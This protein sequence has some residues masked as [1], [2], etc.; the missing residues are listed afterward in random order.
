VP[1]SFSATGNADSSYLFEIGKEAEMSDLISLV[2]FPFGFDH[3]LNTKEN[4]GI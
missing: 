1:K 4:E 3:L 2:R